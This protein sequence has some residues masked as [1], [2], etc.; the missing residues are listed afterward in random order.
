MIEVLG[1]AEKVS[2]SGK[3]KMFRANSFVDSNMHLFWRG[4]I[5]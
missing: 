1:E 3:F 4:T 5:P 2:H